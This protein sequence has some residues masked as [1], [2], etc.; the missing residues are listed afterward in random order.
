LYIAA[1]NNH[2]SCI[3]VLIRARADVN[4]ARLNGTTP[5]F[6]ACCNGRTAC[7]RALLRANADMSLEWDGWTPLQTAI[8]HCHHEVVRLLQE[9]LQFAQ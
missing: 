8:K 1:R 4:R 7:V 5:L 3:E 6:S 2:P 9:A